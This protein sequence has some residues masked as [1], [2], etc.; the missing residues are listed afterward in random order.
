[1]D[2]LPPNFEPVPNLEEAKVAW[3]WAWDLHWITFTALFVLLAV[4]SFIA[5]VKSTRIKKQKVARNL[6]YAVYLLL[7]AL[8][9]TR[10]LFLSLFPYELQANINNIPPAITRLLFGV[11]FPCLTAAF[12]LIQIAFTESTKS[13]QIA[14]SK[15]GKIKFLIL[16]IAVHFGIVV[17]VDIITTLVMK[18]SF[19][20]VL[21]IIYFLLMTLITG[22][23]ITYSGIKVVLEGNKNRK[24]IQA[25]TLKHSYGR[26]L[27]SSDSSSLRAT[28]K[29]LIIAISTALCCLF[30][31]SVQLYALADIIKYLMD[32]DAPKP[33]PWAWYTFQTF[34]RLTELAM[35]SI[36]LYTVSPPSRQDKKL[37]HAAQCEE[38][39]DRSHTGV[40]TK[41]T[42][43]TPSENRE[44]RD[45]QGTW[46]S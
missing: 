46:T 40:Q 3:R 26:T 32:P 20:Y 34:F 23:R 44:Q 30:L 5:L 28:R 33:S 1:M 43:L 38:G 22:I 19:L 45:G 39:I 25:L 41:L 18:T 14:Y 9:V 12:A 2:R 27:Q 13:S 24:V 42:S 29:V 7:V 11:G 8:G 31:V 6:S 10:A 17:L 4:C 15:V 35:A 16:V 21:C 37:N 36:V